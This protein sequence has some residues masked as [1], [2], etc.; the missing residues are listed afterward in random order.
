[1][2][3]GYIIDL[4]GIIQNKDLLIP[5]IDGLYYNSTNPMNLDVTWVLQ[6]RDDVMAKINTSVDKHVFFFVIKNDNDV[7]PILSKCVS[8]IQND[9]LHFNQNKDE[10]HIVCNFLD[11]TDGFKV[12]TYEKQM[13][14]L[15]DNRV[16]VYSWFL[17]KYDNNGDR[18]IGNERRVHAIVRLA[19]FV[20]KQNDVITHSIIQ[21]T[22]DSES[23]RPTYNLFGNASIFF[24]EEKRTESVKDYYCYKSLQHLL[25]LSDADLSKYFDDVVLPQKDNEKERKKR[26][27]ATLDGFLKEHHTSIE[28]SFITEKTQGLLIK[29]SDDDKEYLVN[30]ADNKLVFIDDLSR[31]DGWQLEGMD[32]FL[33]DYQARVGLEKEIQEVVSDEFIADLYS[34]VRTHDRVDFNSIN[35]SVSEDRRVHVNAFKHNADK[36]LYYFLNQ[37]EKGNYHWLFEVLPSQETVK[38]Q[39]NIDFGIAF[40]EYLEKG[41][42]EYLVDQAVSIGDT[43][44]AKIKE[45]N[46]IEEEKRRSAYQEKNDVFEKN[47]KPQ[48]EEKEPTVKL[49]FNVLDNTIKVRRKEKLRCD[50]QL[51]HWV[52]NDAAQKWTARTKSVFFFACGLLASVLW[53][54]VS[55]KYLSGFFADKF[56]HYGRYQWSVF[57]SFLLVGLVIGAIILLRA[58]REQKKA[59]EALEEAR[60]QKRLFMDKCVKDAIDLT[61]KHYK[62]LLAFHGLKTMEELVDYVVWKKEDLLSFKKT[63]FKLMIDY[64]LSADNGDNAFSDENNTIELVDRKGSSILFKSDDGTERLIPFCFASDD[65]GLSD[66]F[67]GF[68]RKKARFETTR[69]SLSHTSFGAFDKEALEK[70]VIACMKDH[71]ESGIVYSSR[72]ATSLLPQTEGVVIDDVN[73]GHCGDCYFMATLAAIA[74][75]NPEYIIGKNGMVSELDPDHQFFRVQF[76]DQDGKRV[77]VDIDNRFWLMNDTPIYA[78]IGKNSENQEANTY[79]PWVMAVEKAWAKA[80]GNGYDGIVGASADGEERERRVEYSFA[81][82]GKSAFYC[83]TKSVTNRNKLLKMMKKHFLDDGLPITLYSAFE[84]D[85]DFVS[86]DENL[87]KG[88]AYALKSINEND[89]FDIFNPWNSHNADENIRGKHYAGVDINFIK[90]NFS[91]V[92]FFGIKES[93]FNSFERELTDNAS[94]NEIIED[95]KGI[96][97]S[98]F[99]RL[100]LN[101][102]RFDDLL[103]QDVMEKALTD[104]MYLYSKNGIKDLG[105]AQLGQP[106]VYLEGGKAGICDDANN[107][108]MNFLRTSLPADILLPAMLHR[109]DDKLVLTLFRLSP[110]YVLESFIL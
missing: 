80:N 86:T 47:Y 91:V 77:N 105:N 93:D 99:S 39:S 8:D 104:S 71:K 66:S 57:F 33:H 59:E 58:R 92:V 67:E 19:E 95:L 70:E 23:P 89:T 97:A 48:G 110:H 84:S 11:E 43:S 79:D 14:G 88:H 10:I 94:E 54:I 101:M 98:G 42:G 60:K 69:R 21:M 85:A 40:M 26:I 65:I 90:D 107:S 75:K 3:I 6:M 41:S 76:Y 13:K 73:Q 52:D 17:G 18:A 15:T 36:Y 29:S 27:D 109:D 46:A 4:C 34:K 106:I 45:D 78:G 53:L 2:N 22:P 87:V 16:C 30:A 82:T 24:D 61:D 32:A 72:N 28:A 63:V 1:M 20:C 55:I 5:H 37:H 9:Q 81:V 103:T 74:Q 38:H 49:K 35:N 64:W 108:L 50:Y 96:L 44:F 56:E 12:K 31:A 68:R 25:N 7:L 100:D 83:M 51:D 102:R 62:H